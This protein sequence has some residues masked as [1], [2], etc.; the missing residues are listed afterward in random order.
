MMETYPIV[1]T[2]ANAV[3]SANTYT[4]VYAQI[5]ATPTINGQN[6]TIQAG[7]ILPIAVQSCSNTA[8]IFLLG[9]P[10]FDRGVGPWD[11]KTGLP[12]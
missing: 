10:L 5:T 8:N 7:T 2:P 11:I 6:I 12:L 3:Y 4:A 9:H 1:H